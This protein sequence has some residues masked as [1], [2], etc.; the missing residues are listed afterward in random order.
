VPVVFSTVITMSVPV[1][2]WLAVYKP[3]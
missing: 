1:M 2:V 3:F